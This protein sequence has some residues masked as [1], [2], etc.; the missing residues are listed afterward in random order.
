MPWRSGLA[1]RVVLVSTRNSTC[2]AFAE[3]LLRPALADTGIEAWAIRVTS[4][5]LEDEQGARFNADAEFMLRALGGNPGGFRATHLEAEIVDDADVLLTMTRA[6]R[7]EVVRRFPRARQRTFTLVEY[8]RLNDL[9]RPMAPLREHPLMLAPARFQA[10]LTDRDDIHAPLEG[11]PQDFNIM[12]TEI[13]E[14]I[15]LLAE[16]WIAMTPMRGPHR[17]PLG[18]ARLLDAGADAEIVRL[19]A[20]G[21]PVDVQCT[22]DGGRA[23]RRLLAAAWSRCLRKEDHPDRE[24][25]LIEAIVHDDP[26]QLRIARARGAIGGETTLDLMHALA[27]AVTVRA[28]DERA[29]EVI[30]LHAAGLALL[31]GRVVAFVAPSGT[32][33]TTLSRTLGRHYGYVSDETVVIGLDGEVTPYPKPLSVI[34][35]KHHLKKQVNPDEERLLM[36]PSNLRLARVVLLNR[37]DHLEGGPVIEDVPLLAGMTEL[38]AQV[39][40][41]P[42]LAEPLRSVARTIERTGGLQRVTYAEASDLIPLV[43]VLAGGV[44]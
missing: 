41:L 39:S 37:V 44:E 35:A 23:L 40:Y 7:D 32:G 6:E 42:R 38:A 29:G 30:M 25:V 11:D 31:D 26:T 10:E 3:R 28:I 9:V 21:V 22:G 16:H 2:A 34:T 33:K 17:D 5:G 12:A 27:G 36:A 1:F 43:P 13:A 15:Y 24:P 4:A 18:A 14:A 8:A 19:S 20:F